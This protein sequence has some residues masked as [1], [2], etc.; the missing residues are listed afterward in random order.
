MIVSTEMH[1]APHGSQPPIRHQ[2]GAGIM[3]KKHRDAEEERD[4]FRNEM[5]GTLRHYDDRIEPYRKK[6]RPVPLPPDKTLFPANEEQEL[7]DLNIET[8][9]ILEFVRPGIQKRLFLELRRGHIPPQA[10]LDLHGFRVSEARLELIRFLA[11]ARQ[12]RLRVIHIIHGKGFGSDTQQPVLKQKTNQ[13][14]RQR[15]EVLAFCSAARFDGGSGAVYVLLK[16]G[17]GRK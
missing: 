2:S 16:R 7:V 9:E 3:T 10:T 15:A 8:G 12:H 1:W 13:W 17:G 5:N 14:L 11:F 6:L 4:L